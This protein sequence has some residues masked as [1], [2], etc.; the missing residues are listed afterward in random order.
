[1]TPFLKIVANNLFS[2]FGNREEGLSDITVVF[3]N[4]R[5]KLFFDQYLSECSDRPIWYPTCMTI[6]EL[7]ESQTNLCIADPLL[8]I[9]RLYDIYIDTTKTNES[10]DSFWTWGEMM[11]SDFSDIDRNMAD[12]KTLFSNIE[13]QREMVKDLSYLTD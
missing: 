13:Q 12:A 6:D 3:P 1:M 7:F 5:A 11:L 2:S 10:I 9:G 4:R 8:L